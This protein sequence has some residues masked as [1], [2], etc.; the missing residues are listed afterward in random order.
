MEITTNN[1][2][3]D[4]VNAGLSAPKKYLSS[5]YF[6]DATGDELFQKIMRLPEYYLTRAEFDILDRYKQDI[7]KPLVERNEQF[8]LFEMGAGDGLKTRN[9]LRHLYHKQFPFT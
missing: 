9:I 6:Y 5:K 1:A 4:E 7:L 2:F 3:A 8:Y